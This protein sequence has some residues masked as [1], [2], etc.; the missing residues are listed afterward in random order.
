MAKKGR[1]PK[2]VNLFNP[3]PSKTSFSDGNKSAGIL[4]DFAVRKAV[5]SQEGT[6]TKVPVNNYDIVNKAYIDSLGIG[7]NYWVSGG[8][9]LQPVTDSHQ[10][11]ASNIIID[12]TISGGVITGTNVTAGA[13]PGHTHT[14]YAAALGADDNYVTDAEKTNIGNLD[15]AAYEAT[16]AFAAALGADD[17]YVTDAEKIVIGNTSGSNTGDQDI[18]GI[19]TNASNITYLSGTVVSNL[20]GSVTTNTS[21][22]S[23]LS[24]TIVAGDIADMTYLSG[25]VVADIATDVAANTVSCATI[26]DISAATLVNTTHSAGDGSDHADVAANTV[27][28]GTIANISAATLLNTTHRNDNTQAHSDYLLNNSDDTMVGVLTMSGGIVAED[29]T[30]ISTGIIRNIILGTD[31]TPPTASGYVTGTIYVQY[32]A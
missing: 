14:A 3:K 22:I 28:C 18:S 1:Q 32:T 8:G 11:S 23:Y 7:A 24:G 4:D 20:S 30:V 27:S 17:N 9:I 6:I 10:L 16:T 29:N 15:S 12:G 5:D 2:I 25:T 19:T 21:D 13:D 26:A 31:E